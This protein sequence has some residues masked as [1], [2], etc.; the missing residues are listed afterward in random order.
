MVTTF[1][2][3]TIKS[4]SVDIQMYYNITTLLKLGTFPV[5]NIT[6]IKRY[7]YENVDNCDDNDEDKHD[8]V[9]VNIA[10]DDEDNYKDKYNGCSESTIMMLV[11]LYLL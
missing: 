8:D 10:E 5:N 4:L 11:K 6:N 9:V 2:N 3:V 1:S 7:I